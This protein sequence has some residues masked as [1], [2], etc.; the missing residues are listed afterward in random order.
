MRRHYYDNFK[1]S[2]SLRLDI[3]GR[4]HISKEIKKKKKVENNEINSFFFFF[5][6]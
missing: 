5:K 2:Q 4:E 1:I 3:I 6:F